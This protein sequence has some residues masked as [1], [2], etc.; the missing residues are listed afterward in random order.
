M[1]DVSLNVEENNVLQLKFPS[2]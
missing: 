2:S 1:M